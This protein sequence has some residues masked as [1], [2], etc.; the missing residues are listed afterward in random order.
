MQL[1]DYLRYASVAG[2]GIGATMTAH[3]VFTD[4]QNW[5]QRRNEQGKSLEKFA[6]SLVVKCQALEEDRRDSLCR[7]L[8][9]MNDNT[10][11]AERCKILATSIK[12]EE[13]MSKKTQVWV[14]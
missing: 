3:Y 12:D 9:L 13:L 7:E 11:L 5:W 1:L 14:R 2:L 6:Q 10:N 4:I 8:G